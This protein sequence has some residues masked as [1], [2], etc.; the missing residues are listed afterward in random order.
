MVLNLIKNGTHDQL[1]LVVRGD[2]DGDARI[3]VADLLIVKKHLLGH[4]KLPLVYAKAA[5]VTG[6]ASVSDADLKRL[7]QHL[8]GNPI[9]P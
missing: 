7:K 9:V 8:L 5:M 6:G 3:T 1:T 2:A 4:I